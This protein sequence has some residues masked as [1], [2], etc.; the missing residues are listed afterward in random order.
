[1]S[2]KDRLLSLIQHYSGGNKSEFARY[3]G[4]TPQ[5][6]STWLSRNTFDI[7][8]I[9]SKCVNIS[10]DW[11][12]TGQGSMLKNNSTQPSQDPSCTI[13]P[14]YKDTKKISNRQL[15]VA[16]NST[17]GIPLIPLHAMAGVLRGEV[18]V[19]EY[20]CEQYVVPAFKGADFLIPV[21]GN[22]MNPTYQSG[23]IVACQRTP[24]SSV[25]FQWNKP[26][27]LDT[28]QGAIIKRI[29]PGQDEEH[30]QIVSDN[31]DYLPFELHKSEIYAVALVIG[32]IR[33]E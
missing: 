7:D 9:Y 15:I 22:S 32:I 12:L 17:K 13:I 14:E 2:K 8:I 11:L 24:M 27:V 5:A 26:Y 6:I 10:A 28:A 33:L 31:T 29:K 19:L 25:F 1:M 21:K 4:V 20:E 16:D 3:I 18:S 23:D 30:V